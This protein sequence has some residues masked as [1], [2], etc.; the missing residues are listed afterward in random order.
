MAPPKMQAV[1]KTQAGAMKPNK[2][3][4]KAT[5]VMK[6]AAKKCDESRREKAAATKTSSKASQAPKAKKTP[7]MKSKKAAKTATKKAVHDADSGGDGSADGGAAEAG[8][9]THIFR[10]VWK[11]QGRRWELRSIEVDLSMG[12]VR[13]EWLWW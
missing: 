9:P 10:K 5:S 7:P 6:A 4:M 12:L 13:E 3:A 2:T 1:A 11:I 8:S